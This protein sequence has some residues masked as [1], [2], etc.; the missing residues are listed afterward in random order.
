MVNHLNQ[1]PIVPLTWMALLWRL[2][3]TALLLLL[4]AAAGTAGF[5]PTL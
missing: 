2:A 3:L 1:S 4:L 5:S